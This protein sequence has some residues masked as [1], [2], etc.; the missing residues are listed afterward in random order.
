MNSL[1]NGGNLTRFDL[2][3]SLQ[4]KVLQV[5]GL[6]VVDQMKTSSS[7][8]AIAGY[9]ASAKAMVD[10]AAG[11]QHNNVPTNLAVHDFVRGN[12]GVTKLDGTVIDK[13]ASDF[14]HGRMPKLYYG[15]VVSADQE[16]GFTVD[17]TVTASSGNLVT[18]GAVQQAIADLIDSAPAN[19][20][21]LK[22]LAQS[23]NNDGDLF[24]TLNSLIATNSTALAAY[25]TLV[26][27]A[28]N[29]PGLI[30]DVVDAY[31]AEFASRDS[32]TTARTAAVDLRMDN[33]DAS[34]AARTSSVDASLSS[35]ASARA[36]ADTAL[37]NDLATEISDRQAA[38]SAEEAARIAADSSEA[39]A[40]ASEISALTT[41]VA[42][43]KTAIEASLA[44]EAS[45]RTSADLALQAAVDQEAADRAAAVT[46]EQ[47]ARVAA[48][49]TL[50]DDLAQEVSDR[51][52][53]I[54]SEASA[55]ST[56]DSELEAS[57]ASEASAR[58]AAISSLQSADAASVIAER[59][60]SDAKYHHKLL[61][62]ADDT[63]FASVKVDSAPAAGVAN[64]VTSAGVFTAI[65]NAKA[66]I[67]NGAPGALDT[68]KEIA[69]AL[70]NDADLAATLTNS[71]AAE[72][73]ARAAADG[74]EQSAREAA[75]LTL[76]TDLAQEVT[77]RTAAVSAEASTRAAAISSEASTRAAAISQEQSD[78]ATA[79]SAEESARIAAIALEQSQRTAKDTEHDTALADR[80]TKAEIDA[81]LLNILGVNSITLAN[82]V[83]LESAAA[84]TVPDVSA[85]SASSLKLEFNGHYLQVT[86]GV[87]GKTTIE[88]DAAN[89]QIGAD[90]A[91]V[92][93]DGEVIVSTGQDPT[94][95]DWD[96]VMLAKGSPSSG[97]V[98][99]FDHVVEDAAN[100]ADVS[101]WVTINGAVYVVSDSYSAGSHFPIAYGNPAGDLGTWWT[102][103]SLRV[104]PALSDGS[105]YTG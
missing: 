16:V 9:S 87:L 14:V 26:G 75:D 97:N 83:V 70:G 49:T 90:G 71:I 48:V 88:A 57:I 50:T 1:S 13:D 66:G 72:A 43:N 33:L 78:R 27:S 12:L 36:A 5:K 44:S 105:V 67:L 17:T 84:V 35:E 21:T 86:G 10:A 101:L 11:T 62:S 73:S 18:A 31:T 22:E 2:A 60:T 19:L 45:T 54:T 74:V 32:A 91:F 47:L 52:A 77:D 42:N 89:L 4:E 37:G 85:S 29:S 96:V 28:L 95:P 94:L 68:L 8:T 80:Y 79:V 92:F 98:V 7:D 55:R 20:D 93:D 38:V 81:L 34:I 23:I 61:N 24:G 41:T 46:S 104:K 59:A 51:Q 15:G 69:D 63:T 65:E 102:I 103:S 39:S 58:A 25:K 64:L 40:R 99:Y 76:T 6:L 82:G 56:K 3:T 100:V 53:A 30:K